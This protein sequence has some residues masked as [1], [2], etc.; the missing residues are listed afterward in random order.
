MRVGFSDLS[1]KDSETDLCV[2]PTVTVK[3]QQAAKDSA[4][5]MCEAIVNHIFRNFI[6]EILICVTQLCLY[7]WSDPSLQCTLYS[8]VL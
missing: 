4:V 3:M 1:P 5:S 2:G 8:V 6:P 7:F